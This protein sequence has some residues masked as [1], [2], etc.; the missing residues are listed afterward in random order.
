MDISSSIT[1]KGNKFTLTEEIAAE[2]DVSFTTKWKGKSW[3][4][5]GHVAKNKKSVHIM[6]IKSL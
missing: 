6:L 1:V 4:F 3:Y 2:K 5:E